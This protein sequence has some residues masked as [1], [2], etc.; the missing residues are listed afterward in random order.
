MLPEGC[1]KRRDFWPGNHRNGQFVR[2]GLYA[3]YVLN[4]YASE[5]G[6]LRWR[7]TIYWLVSTWN[8]Y[9]QE[10]ETVGRTGSYPIPA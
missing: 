3:P 5:A 8:P 4:R 7:S 2:G 10:I 9:G 1:G 6:G